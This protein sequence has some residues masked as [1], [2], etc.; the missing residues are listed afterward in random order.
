M[1]KV[2]RKKGQQLEYIYRKKDIFSIKILYKIFIIKIGVVNLM[3]I[4][5]N[6]LKEIIKIKYESTVIEEQEG[7]N[8]KEIINK[9]R[10]YKI[11]EN[12]E[13]C[14][15]FTRV[16]ILYAIVSVLFFIMLA[17]LLYIKTEKYG[18]PI[19]FFIFSI[20]III[21]MISFGIK[22]GIKK[23]VEGLTGIIDELVKILIEL[24]L[25]SGINAIDK[26]NKL[27]YIVMVVILPIVKLHLSQKKAGVVIY[28]LIEEIIIRFIKNIKKYEKDIMEENEE[29]KENR[30]VE[31]I[32]TGKEI[33]YKVTQ[34]LLKGVYLFLKVTGILFCSIGILMIIV[35]GI[36]RIYINF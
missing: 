35:L 33:G 6:N 12:A 21:G 20:P 1:L 24:E 32:K 27:N 19:L 15:A 18:F 23:S 7:I 29:I 13:V 10:V 8:Y 9:E 14:F 2:K 16:V 22:R 34:K 26:K 25:E 31:K 11:L 3:K 4:D 17:I 30:I 5:A 36:F 28:K